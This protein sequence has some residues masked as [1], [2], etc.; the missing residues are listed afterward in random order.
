MSHTLIGEVLPDL[1][2]EVPDKTANQQIGVR[3]S[4]QTPAGTVAPSQ[5]PFM[6]TV[7]SAL[8]LEMTES[9][10]MLEMAQCDPV[11]SPHDLRFES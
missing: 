10:F 7:I 3:V 8:H 6:V 5:V 4:A 9:T 2:D 11:Q 1:Q